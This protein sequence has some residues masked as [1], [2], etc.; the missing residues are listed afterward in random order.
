MQSV[1]S[2]PLEYVILLC[3]KWE[4]F[5]S[6]WLQNKYILLRAN[7]ISNDLQNVTTKKT[8]F[9]CKSLSKHLVAI[10]LNL[11]E[12][13]FVVSTTNTQFVTLKTQLIAHE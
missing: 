8:Y 3:Q 1:S 11:M 9:S 2:N 7:Q 12:D 4:K 10:S 5:T 6:E 13:R